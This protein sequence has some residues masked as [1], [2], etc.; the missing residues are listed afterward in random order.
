MERRV[1][2]SSIDTLF[3]WIE[4]ERLADD[5]PRLSSLAVCIRLTLRTPHLTE[6]SAL[7]E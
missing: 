4:R 3:A 1:S 2:E 7:P 6:L 5:P